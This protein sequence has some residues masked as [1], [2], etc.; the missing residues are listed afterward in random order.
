MPGSTP[1]LSLP[2]PT[3]SDAV[4]VPRDIKAIADAIDPLGR[5]Y[6]PVG[7]MM[8]WLTAAAPTNWLLC[9]GALVSAATYPALA[10]V[11]GSA[12]GNIT[13]PDLKG[14]F[15]IGVGQ[16][17][18]PVN[19]NHPLG[20]QGGT[21][22]VPLAVGEL[23]A[24]THSDGTLAVASHAHGAGTLAAVAVADHQH[25]QDN[26]G[27]LVAGISTNTPW[28]QTHARG[29]DG[30]ADLPI[31]AY[32]AGGTLLNIQQTGTAGAHGHS[33][34]GSSA[35]VAPDVAG[36]TGSA[37]SGTGHENMPP[38]VTVNFIIRA[39]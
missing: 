10:A 6:V 18:A 22:K 20:Q 17:G 13:L 9:N 2:Y 8:M 19:S 34:S 35:S 25:P 7:A 4:D 38:F 39:L 30:G 36:S 32:N 1:I 31:V 11:L 28:F 37:G 14:R 26:S 24:H 3:P 12:G 27:R 33:V 15:P 29:F 21:E 5:G 16:S 23:A